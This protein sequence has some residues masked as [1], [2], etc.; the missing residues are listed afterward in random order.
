MVKIKRREI[1]ER[2]GTF[3]KIINPEIDLM[4]I[5]KPPTVSLVVVSLNRDLPKN[6]TENKEI[7]ESK[8]IYI[9][10]TMEVEIVLNPLQFIDLSSRLLKMGTWLATKEPEKYKEWVDKV[11]GDLGQ[12]Q[13][14]IK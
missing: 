9:Q 1:I 11:L 14:S 4:T 3:K 2:S 5:D 10:P 6:H 13:K 8:S 7:E 12:I